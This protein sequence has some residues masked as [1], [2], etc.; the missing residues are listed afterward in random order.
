MCTEGILVKE[1]MEP[2]ACVKQ[3][4]QAAVRVKV[5]PDV[6]VK[7]EPG[8]F[9]LPSQS[10]LK[11]PTIVFRSR[12]GQQGRLLCPKL[13]VVK[14]EPKEE[15]ATSSYQIKSEQAKPYQ[16]RP[17]NSSGT[18]SSTK[19]SSRKALESCLLSSSKL[20][21]GELSLTEEEKRT[22]V[23]EGYP[24]PARLPLTKAEERSLKKIRRKIK[25][26]ISA[27]ESRRKK[28]EYL[29]R[30]ELRCQKVEGERE[31]WRAKCL[32]LEETNRQLQTQL[33]QLQEKA[34]SGGGFRGGN[35]DIDVD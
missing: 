13:V 9:F 20:C 8:S 32:E 19:S 27:Q 2:K 10:L 35:L 18:K 14:T 26:K 23:S 31:R 16:T 11:Q 3:E 4:E 5:E 22:L 28:K 34:L 25:N 7:Q 29:D 33:Q 12:N 1:E 6:V 15:E 21:N 30:L 24:V 17:S